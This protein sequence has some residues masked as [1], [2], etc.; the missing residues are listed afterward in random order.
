MSKLKEDQSESKEQ[1]K[2]EAV[3]I[4]NEI[5]DKEISMFSLPMQTV[6]HYCKPHFVE[7]N[8]LYLITNATS[9]LPA[10]E[11]VLGP[12]FLLERIDKYLAV[13]RLK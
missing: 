3:K 9:T 5:K 6:S 13:S 12:K 4:W 10:L 8:R 2:T 7:P 1:P 11:Q